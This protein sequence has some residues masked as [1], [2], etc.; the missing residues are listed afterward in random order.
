[1]YLKRIEAKSSGCLILSAD[2]I[3]NCIKKIL[4]QSAWLAICGQ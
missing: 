4:L 1:M 3:N 2:Q